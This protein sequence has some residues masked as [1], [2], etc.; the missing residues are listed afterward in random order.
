MLTY[1]NICYNINSNNIRGGNIMKAQTLT[2]S[3]PVSSYDSLEKLAKESDRSKGYLIR[4]AVENY[5]EDVYLYKKAV[6]AL[7]KNEPTYSLE[8]IAKEYGL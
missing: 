2:I 4:K 1:V 3:L 5:L 6:A 7:E 8:D